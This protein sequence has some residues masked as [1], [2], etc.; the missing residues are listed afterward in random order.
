MESI[1]L[2]DCAETVQFHLCAALRVAL[3]ANVVEVLRERGPSV[4]AEPRTRVFDVN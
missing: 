2:L 4:S 1:D 3:E